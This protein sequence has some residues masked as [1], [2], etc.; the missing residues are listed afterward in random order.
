MKRMTCTRLYLTVSAVWLLL[1]LVLLAVLPASA[2]SAVGRIYDSEAELI[3]NGEEAALGETLQSLSDQY[4]VEMYL[5]TYRAEGWADDFVGDDYCRE[6]RELGG[7]D[8]VLLIV[9]YDTRDGKYYYDMYTYGQ[10]DMKISNK[11][12][13][14]ILDSDGVYDNIKGGRLS[15]GAEA[16]FTLSAKAYKGRVGAS[17]AVIIP[18]CAIL[19]GLI[20][21][22][23]AKGV[24]DSYKK[25]HRSVDYPLDRY[26]KLEL[27][28]ESDT[29]AGTAVTRSYSPRSRSGG[30]GGGSAHGGGGGHRGG[31]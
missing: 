9:T 16:F 4:D 18:V 26:A 17:Y 10:A 29:F 23:V 5:A 11:E 7:T 30:G 12:V 15:A 3:P 14:Y 13:N 28:S 20:G 19:A 21:I 6:I 27:K 24:S 2:E 25:K 31:R 22:L 8:A 1:A